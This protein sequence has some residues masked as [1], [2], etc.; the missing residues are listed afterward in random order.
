MQP[1]DYRPTT[2]VIF[3]IGQLEQIGTIARGLGAH[4]A[5]LVTDPGIIAAGHVERA[6]RVLQAKP[7]TAFIFDQVEENPT[8][9][10]IEAG[11]AFA[12]ANAPIDLIIALGGGSAMD[13]AKGINFILTNSGKMEDYWGF[14]KATQPMLP[15]I[16]VPTTAG[17]GSEAQSYAL[18]SKSNSHEKMACGDLKARFHVAILDPTLL[19]SASARVAAISGMD[20]ISHAIESYVS[21]KRNGVSQLFAKEAWR[22]LSANFERVLDNA[23]DLEAQGNMLLG[24]HLAGAAIENSM[25]GAAHACA[26]P[27]T[28]QFGITHGVAVGIMLP[29][30]I[31]F[32]RDAVSAEYHELQTADGGSDLLARLVTLQQRA[33]LP[34][35][36]RACEVPHE[37]LSGLAN[38]ATTQWTGRFNPRPLSERDFLDLYQRAY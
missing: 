6:L 33:G 37:A 34:Q 8:T 18:I 22:L 25:L 14:G 2:R 27:L 30:V 23:H 10:H 32:N 24:A 9:R 4:R 7:I 1:F 17:T 38:A 26:N 36:L 29:H 16:G 12:Q 35:T 20:A 19:S 21:T 5:M 3:G 13:C 31:R 15:S 11:V 28:A